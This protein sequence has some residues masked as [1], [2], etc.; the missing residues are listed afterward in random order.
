MVLAD[1]GADV[2]KVKRLHSGKD[3]GDMEPHR[4]SF[5]EP[6]ALEK[7]DSASKRDRV[8]NQNRERIVVLRR[9]YLV[10]KQGGS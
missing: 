3:G 6:E 7:R 2:I 10:P 4:G 5:A 9:R 8:F 1:L